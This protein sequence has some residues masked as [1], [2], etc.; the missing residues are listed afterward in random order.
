MRTLCVS[1]RGSML[2]GSYRTFGIQTENVAHQCFH[3]Q[4][5]STALIMQEKSTDEAKSVQENF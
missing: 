4:T 5:D 2:S 3:P 1:C